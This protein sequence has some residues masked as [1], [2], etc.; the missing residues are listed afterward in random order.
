M[1]GDVPGEKFRL[2]KA[3]IPLFAP[4]QRHRNNGVEA[5]LSRRGGALHVSGQRTRQRFHSRIFEEMNQGAKSA[6]VHA[7]A[8]GVIESAQAGAASGADAAVVQ[9][10]RIEERGI[11]D[12]TEI[13]GVERRAGAL[14]QSLQTGTVGPLTSAT[15]AD[16][17]IVR[18]K[19]RKNSVRGSP[20]RR[21]KRSRSRYSVTREGAPPVREPAPRRLSAISWSRRQ[22]MA[23]GIA[24]RRD[25]GISSPQTAQ[26]P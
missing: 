22:R 24:S 4:M 11:A 12:R 6:F 13:F 9:R 3:A 7:E 8:G 16:A 20:Y 17:A 23:Q 26:V 18:E 15:F 1:S 10:I 2:I 21:S 25:F 14:R 19:Q 5:F